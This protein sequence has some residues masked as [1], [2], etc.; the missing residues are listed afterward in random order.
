[1]GEP[2]LLDY[3]SDNCA[4]METSELAPTMV[5]IFSWEK[6]SPTREGL[7]HFIRKVFQYPRFRCAIGEHKGRRCYREIDDAT[8]DDYLRPDVTLPGVNCHDELQTWIS[9]NLL[10]VHFAANAA[11]W[12]VVPVRYEALPDRTDGVLLMSHTLGDGITLAALLS[13]LNEEEAPTYTPSVDTTRGTT[14]KKSSWW[15]SLLAP[16]INVSLF[17]LSFF[18]ILG[19]P[20]FPP[21]SLWAAQRR[22][23]F[24]KNR[25]AAKTMKRSCTI[26]CS[27]PLAK[28]RTASHQLGVK[29]NDIITA[30]V[31]GG[32][33][34]YREHESSKC[35]NKLGSLWDK[36][37]L[38]IQQ[39]RVRALGTLDLR[40][41]KAA[42]P[43][44][45]IEEA[46]SKYKQN[47][48]DADLAYYI[49]SL[50]V[51]SKD[52]TQRLKAAAAEMS[53]LKRSAEP[54]I[55]SKLAWFTWRMMGVQKV[56][57]LNLELMSCL[58]LLYSNMPGPASPIV[59]AGKE[60]T[61]LSYGVYNSAFPLSLCMLS[62]NS[63]LT[64]VLVSYDEAVTLPKLLLTSI[65]E[66]LDAYCSV[67]DNMSK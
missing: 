59:I 18:R 23:T 12:F 13:A 43:E 42:T 24:V 21:D 55:A 53:R 33:K 34:T 62:Y 45:A 22:D 38:P 54:V 30:A 14:K 37:P 39:P 1:M 17:M 28:L 65:Q 67:V 3:F 32:I 50:P 36:L 46:V 47:K 20:A 44:A 6:G 40:L 26:S 2:T 56:S 9:D 25:N 8:P 29:V 41:R 15:W 64:L 35:V 4:H 49:C 19:M 66:E 52:R 63:Q 51:E 60:C 5:I 61:S 48:G 31:A 10:H 57:Q 58:T 11:P 27:Y 16:L 7:I